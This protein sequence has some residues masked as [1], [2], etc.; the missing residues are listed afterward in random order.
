MTEQP[1]PGWVRG[2]EV[3]SAAALDELSRLSKENAELRDQLA[4]LDRERD[5][6]RVIDSLRRRTIS[7]TFTDQTPFEST[8]LSFFE[9]IGRELTLERQTAEIAQLFVWRLTDDESKGINP[10]FAEEWLKDLA[11]YDLVASRTHD[12][13]I[14]QGFHIEVHLWW[15][16]S[17]GKKA[18]AR[19]GRPEGNES[20]PGGS[21]ST[22]P[23]C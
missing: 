14:G 1:R 23:G 11:L 21:G 9:A 12:R 10:A 22:P 18:R 5:V 20:D 7:G 8:L 6:T 2:S 16:T 3:P 4:K 17:L 19:I 13:E 15:L